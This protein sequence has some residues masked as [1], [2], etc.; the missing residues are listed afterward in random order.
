MIFSLP[1]Y[2][3]ILSTVRID[4]LV[5]PAVIA[6]DCSSATLECVYSGAGDDVT[7]RWLL[8]GSQVYEWREGTE[9]RASG[10][11]TG[12]TDLSYRMSSK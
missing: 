11:L 12:R 10:V 9:P 4:K 7:V 1:T 2:T 3:D 5:V 6:S 8:N